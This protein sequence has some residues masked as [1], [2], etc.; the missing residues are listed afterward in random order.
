MSTYKQLKASGTQV[1]A[2]I[3]PLTEE[4]ENQLHTKPPVKPRNLPPEKEGKKPRQP[5]KESPF[6]PISRAAQKVS[7]NP[8]VK[9]GLQV[10]QDLTSPDGGLVRKGLDLA[11][12]SGIAPKTTERAKKIFTETTTALDGTPARI[13]E[14]VANTAGMVG[15]ALTTGVDKLGGKEVD[16][17]LNPFSTKYI[18]TK[19]DTGLLIPETNSGKMAQQMLSFATTTVGIA[20]KLPLM[21]KGPKALKFIVN[22]EGAGA[23]ADV[24]L[25]S[26]DDGV[27]SDFIKNALPEKHQDNVLLF[28]S[29][30][31]E[32]ATAVGARLRAATEG[33]GLGWAMSILGAI[34]HARGVNV[35]GPKAEQVAEKTRIFKEFLDKEAAKNL[36]AATKESNTWAEVTLRK[37]DE[38]EAKQA[39]AKTVGEVTDLNRSGVDALLA[40]QGVDAPAAKADP[41]ASAAK[42]SKAAA[43]GATDPAAPKA[44]A[45]SPRVDPDDADLDAKYLKKLQNDLDRGYTPADYDNLEPQ[46]RAATFRP[47]PIPGVPGKTLESLT[48]A[49]KA[50]VGIGD[51]DYLYQVA[52]KDPGIQAMIERDGL[53]DRK[54]FEQAVTGLN[55]ILES[56]GARNLYTVPDPVESLRKAGFIGELKMG[57]GARRRQLSPA[58]VVASLHQIK[59]IAGESLDQVKRFQ[60]LDGKG[61]PIGNSAD[62]LITDMRALLTLV[63]ETSMPAG[64]TVRA[65]GLDLNGPKPLESLGVGGKNGYEESVEMLDKIQK[66]L[67]IGDNTEAL[68]QLRV[69]AAGLRA[70]NGNPAR[71]MNFWRNWREQSWREASGTMINS[72]FSGVATQARSLTGNVY[73]VLERPTSLM[74]RGITDGDARAAGMA[75]YKALHTSL[76]ESIHAGFKVAFDGAGSAKLADNKWVEMNALRDGAMEEIWANADTPAKQVA[77]QALTFAR[78]FNDNPFFSYGPKLLT[79]GD[80]AFQ[81]LHLRSWAASDSMYKASKQAKQVGGN[82]DDLYRKQLDIFNKEH[83]DSTGR[84]INEDMREWIA[85]GTFQGQTAEWVQSVSSLMNNIPAMRY[86]VPVVRTPA[87]IL[88]YAGSHI[89]YANQLFIHDFAKVKA[90]ALKGDQTAMLKLASYEGRTAVGMS[91]VAAGGLLA[92]NSGPDFEINGFGPPPGSKEWKTWKNLGKQPM[93][94]KFG[95]KYYDYSSVEPLATFFGVIGDAAMIGRMSEADGLNTWSTQ[96]GFTIASAALDKTFMQGIQEMAGFLDLTTPL[97][98]KESILA[99]LIANQVPLSGLR[100][101]AYNTMQPLRKEY[102][103]QSDRVWDAATFG[104]ANKGAIYTDPMTRE[105]E[106]SYG[107]GFYN[108]NTAVRISPVN[109]DPLKDRLAD[110]GFGY[111]THD[112]G[113]SNMKLSPEDTQEIHKLMFDLG[114][115]DRLEEALDDPQFQDL[116]DSWDDRPFDQ[117][118]PSS[119]PAHIRHL[120]RIWNG[121][122]QEAIEAFMDQ[123]DEFAA[124]A[125]GEYERARDHR[126]AMYKTGGQAPDLIQKLTGMPK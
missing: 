105:S 79:A 62:K 114:I 109:K 43:K 73:T 117:N 80:E 94:M 126:A 122:R 49:Q 1:S 19:L 30:D 118:E 107:G 40:K 102:E 11:E 29:A 106:L 56:T 78:W 48:D 61:L 21:T 3:N 15:D 124:R 12:K 86:F 87:N 24:L 58:G 121:T 16:D 64:Q 101:G 2:G 46:E 82:V 33:A 77:A 93:T 9:K 90:A 97:D 108:A 17:T 63:K 59:Q 71:V 81:M 92:L 95:D 39:Q 70:N 22:T 103:K 66:Q 20:S 88:Y 115:R 91:L 116:V 27:L 123:N 25:S 8:I 113:P 23:I 98:R 76:G 54:V 65:Y 18:E 69:L 100:R 75:G 32:K 104:L 125:M 84:I 35:K 52:N 31:P 7:G 51:T 6:A 28:L 53:S 14:G 74:L 50:K 26:K 67:A 110:M 36:D 111:Q 120:Q 89:P 4:E 68:K 85:Q 10:A 99:S 47:E 55:E 38:L 37:I 45:S 5:R 60:S 41:A 44:E 34:R 119:A 83:I 57:D 96:L 72:I 42:D 112:R 13:A